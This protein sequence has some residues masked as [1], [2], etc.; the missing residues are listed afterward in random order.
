[1]R[2][3]KAALCTLA[4]STAVLPGVTAAAAAA[5]PHTA[6]PPLM[7]TSQTPWVTPSDPWF[8]LALGIGE[9]GVA[10][11]DLHVSMTVYTRIGD[12]SQYVQATGATPEKGVLLHL[13]DLAVS[14][15]AG[16]RTA[17]TCVTVLPESSSSAPAVPTG[18]SGA[19]PAASPTLILSCTPDTGVCGDVYPVSI[20]LL[21]KGSSTPLA[22]FTTYLTYQEPNGPTGDDGALRV[23]VIAPVR[24][25][26]AAAD[27]AV[28]SAH[29]EVPVTLEVNPGTVPALSAKGKAGQ[30]A[31]AQ[32]AGLTTGSTGAAADDQLLSLPYVPIDPA[33]L[34]AAGLADEISAQLARGTSLL[35]AGG[36]HP[37]GGQWV[38]T[39]STLVAGDAANL[40]TGLSKA[41][42]THLVLSD[43]NLAPGGLSSITFAQPFTLD[44]GHDS[45]LMAAAANSEL[46]ARFTADPG[47][48]VLAA[49]QLLAGLS[50]IHFE[51]TFLDDPRGVVVDAPESWQ[52]QSSFMATL[53]AGLSDNP[54]LKPVTLDQFFA[55]V[56][57]GGN[58]EPSTRQLQP[59][60]AGSG[61][62]SHDAA[63][64]ISLARQH[65]A[66]FIG[67]VT[68]R[69]AVLTTLSDALLDTE[70]AGLSTAGRSTAIAGYTRAFDRQVDSISLASERT[71]TFTSRTAPIPITVLSSAP[72]PVTVVMSLQSDKFTFPAGSTRTLHL[73]RPT[74]S[75]RLQAHA[76]SSG[77]RLPIDVTLRTPDGRLV[78]SHAELT[79]HSTAISI[80]GIGLTV[81]AGLVLVVWW[82]RTWRR[83]RRRR[84]RAH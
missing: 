65:L 76:I 29:H 43:A 53:V 51:N 6:G 8:N 22:R 50:F 80:V 62:I 13:P 5:R 52:P 38:D 32:L 14:G 21:R 78:L 40:A 36:L 73:D 49:T 64:K 74:T 30:R 70:Q 55:Q 71:V 31:L 84:P 77:D 54:V 79:V 60:S 26:Q 24:G 3:A 15:G 9:G 58:R 61:Q 44:L 39:T 69:P 27:T 18:T 46:S 59:G 1:M 72:F 7:L 57:V 34:S 25:P 67:A 35:R 17:S 42:A 37:S 56:P 2:W 10:A 75:V 19:C 23:G 12:F 41:G 20:A 4:L 28:L 83:S 48:P 68:G 11:A 47:D 63:Q 81:L 16:N 33:A 66:S 45:H 82:A